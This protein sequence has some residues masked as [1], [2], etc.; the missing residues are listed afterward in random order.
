M[1]EQGYFPAV[2]DTKSHIHLYEPDL[3]QVITQLR[4]RLVPPGK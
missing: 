3:L 4:S 1:W 2:V